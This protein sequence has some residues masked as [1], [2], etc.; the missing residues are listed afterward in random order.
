MLRR[1]KI[2]IISLLAVATILVTTKDSSA[3][4]PTVSFT[5]NP[6]ALALNIKP[7]ATQ[8]ETIQIM[9]NTANP[10]PIVMSLKTFS[11]D[12]IQ[13]NA[14]INDFSSND[15]TSKYVTFNPSQF[16]SQPNIW[17]KVKVKI[18]L[19]KN[20]QL[21]YYYA[22]VFQPILNQKITGKSAVYQ[23]NNAVLLLIDTQSANEA[24]AAQ[25]SSF[26]V[27]KGLSE[28]LPVNF[29]VNI[30]NNGNIF[31]SPSGDIFISRHKDGSHT[32]DTLPVNNGGGNILPNS[33]RIFTA[34]WDNG[35]PQ[36]TEK[37]V[38]GKL[39]VDKHS[40][41]VK[42]LKWDITKA[43]KLRFGKYY[44]KLN[45]QY[46]NGKQVVLLNSVVSFWVIPWKVLS[47][48]GVIAAIFLL[49]SVLIIRSIIRRIKNRKSKKSKIATNK[50]D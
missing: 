26:T 38:N 39:V 19:P 12:G 23:T 41:P 43:N 7:G 21:G 20:A 47:V 8:E 9:N 18:S 37:Y 11:A 24:K 40:N 33:N 50:K 35:F 30:R 2:L 36:F 1:V 31:L 28:Y 29:K 25:V 3:A 49:I 32:I 34:S 17:T 14:A 44:A 42:Q 10:T 13:G 6:V 4:S 45:M 5:T 16:I 15:P 46:N 22:L 27:T 48:I